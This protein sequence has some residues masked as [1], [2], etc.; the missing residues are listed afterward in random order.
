MSL[1]ETIKTKRLVL[2]PF[3]EKHFSPEYVGWLNDPEVMRFSEQRHR[4]HTLESCKEYIDSFKGAVNY[5]WVILVNDV[6]IGHIGN[7]SVHVDT[8]NNIA[9]I[10]ILIGKKQVWGQGFG[11]EA[12][13][14]ICNYLV[15]KL[16]IRKVTAGTLSTNVA[17]FKVMQNAGMVEDGVRKRHYMC[18]GREVDIVHMAIFSKSWSKTKL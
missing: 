6:G 14:G 18:E 12:F 10:S 2:E 16:K 17:M 9:D 7:I 11:S 13:I 5:I 3:S 1:G 4:K 15:S 8:N